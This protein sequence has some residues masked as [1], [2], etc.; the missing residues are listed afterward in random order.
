MDV[1]QF[2]AP[3]PMT[4]GVL[5]VGGV[6]QPPQPPQQMQQQAPQGPQGMPQDQAP[7]QPPQGQPPSNILQMT[8][9]GQAMNAIKPPQMARGGHIDRDTMM[10][11][12]INRKMKVNHG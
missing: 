2:F 10:L 12:L 3:R 1:K 11:A 6:Q 5:P 4:T 8:P 9:Q 7:A